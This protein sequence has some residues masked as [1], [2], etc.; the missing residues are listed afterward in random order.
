MP[1]INMPILINAA[2]MTP[3]KRSLT[4]SLGRPLK[5]NMKKVMNSGYANDR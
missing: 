4:K 5:K 2:V 3:A 1:G